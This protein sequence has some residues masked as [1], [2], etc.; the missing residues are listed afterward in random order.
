VFELWAEQKFG[1]LASIRIGQLTADNQFFISEFAN[2]LYVNSTFAWPTIFRADLP[3]GGGPNYPL[4]TPGVRLKLTPDKH[5]AILCRAVHWRS[6]RIRVLGLEGNKGS[7]RNKF[8]SAG[9]APADRRNAI[10]L[11]P[12]QTAHGLAGTIKLGGLYHF[13]T[14]NDQHFDVEGQSLASP[15]SNGVARTHAGDYGVYGVIDQML[16]R[17]PGDDPKKVSVL[18]PAWQHSR[19][20]A[21]S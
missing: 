11:Q 4:A 13:G 5:L 19:P 7:S 16:W 9:S 18:L 20:I 21:T 12:R 2:S 3:G 17:L 6:C 8:S 10:F 1:D 14:F 15:T